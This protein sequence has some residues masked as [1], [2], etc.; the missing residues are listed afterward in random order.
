VKYLQG[1]NFLLLAVAEKSEIKNLGRAAAGL[2]IS[3][4]STT[5]QTYGRK[6]NRA[7]CAQRTWLSGFVE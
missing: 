5:I 3:Q 6:F 2:F 7:I 1:V 4:S